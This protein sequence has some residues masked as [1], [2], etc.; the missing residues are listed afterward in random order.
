MRAYPGADAQLSDEQF[1]LV[2]E[3]APACPD[4]GI[5]LAPRFISVDPYLRA[6]FN[7]TNYFEPFRMGEPFSSTGVS[8]VL[9]S[10][11][12]RFAAGDF[13]SGSIVWAERFATTDGAAPRPRARHCKR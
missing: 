12:P 9:E 6:R 13:V 2:E 5:L 7:R 10:R 11:H 8:E 4:G 1:E 3:S